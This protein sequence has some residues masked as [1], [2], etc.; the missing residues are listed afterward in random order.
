MDLLKTFDTLFSRVYRDYVKL[1]KYLTVGI[2]GTL[3]D[4][5]IF[6]FIIGYTSLFYV[7][8]MAMSYFVGMIIN[9][10]LNR[11]FTFNNTYKKVHYQFATFALIALIGLG[12]QEALMVGLVHYLL[13]DTNVDLMLM[14]SRAIATF[15]G[16][17]WTFIAN[18]KIT[19]KVF[20]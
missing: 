18:K 12:I 8:A 19:F 3:A 20:R 5:M 9:Y 6:A 17:I 14:A 4:W 11:R 15:A 10:V 2:V 7:L 16:F 13:A 1:A